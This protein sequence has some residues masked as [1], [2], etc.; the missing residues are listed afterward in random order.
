ML[1]KEIIGNYRK[2]NELRQ[3]GSTRFPAQVSFAIIRNIK[4]LQSIV[5][6]IEK[7]YNDLVLQY[8]DPIDEPNNKHE[9]YR[10]KPEFIETFNKE[11]QQLEQINVDLNLILIPFSEIQDLNL[12][13][14]EMDALFF[15][16]KEE[17]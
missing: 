6:D 14:K 10:V 2:L 7:T 5:D 16:I 17:T 12:S 11:I 3:N 13:L 8:A 4:M 1:N 9:N 15:M